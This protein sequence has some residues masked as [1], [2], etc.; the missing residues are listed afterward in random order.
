MFVN[1]TGTLLREY[2]VGPNIGDSFDISGTRP[3]TSTMPLTIT[4]SPYDW[5]TQRIARWWARLWPQ[6]DPIS[7][8]IHFLLVCGESSQLS[9][10]ILSSPS[11]SHVMREF[12]LYLLFAKTIYQLI[13]ASASV[14]FTPC[15]EHK[16]SST[17]WD[18][19][20]GECKKRAMEGK[21]GKYRFFFKKNTS[22]ANT[23]SI[24]NK[25][26]LSEQKSTINAS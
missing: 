15:R 4:G 25:K 14:T 18:R 20:C 13:Q 3:Q 5:M 2:W 17:M 12:L 6:T 16:G 1:L 9:L 26:A 8:T 7:P 10:W 24:T 21:R 23:K 19:C 11:Q 22:Q